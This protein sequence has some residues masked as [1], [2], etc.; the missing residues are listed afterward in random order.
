MM[1]VIITE[2]LMLSYGIKISLWTDSTR[3]IIIII[4]SRNGDWVI[5]YDEFEFF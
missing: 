5:R 1:V 2:K 3:W 4:N